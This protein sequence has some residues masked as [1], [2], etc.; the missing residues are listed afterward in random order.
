MSHVGAG[1]PPVADAGA[2]ADAGPPA[3]CLTVDRW[4]SERN[5]LA[6]V[7]M[8]A[9][10]L[11][12]ALAVS[13][14]GIAYAALLGVFFFAAHVG[15]VAH[16]RGSAVRLGPEQMP[17]LH[18]R[19]VALSRRI[20]LEPPAA[21]LMQA[22]GTLNALATRFLRSQ[23]IVLYSELLDACGDNEDARDF[24]IAHEL[25]HLK[26]GHLRGRWF[27][28]PGLLV[29]FLGTAYSRA[30][31]FTSDRYGLAAAG[32]R[33]RALDGLCILAAGGRF[34]P[35]VNRRALAA[36]RPDLDTFW[37]TLGR[38]MSTHPPIAARLAALDP[39][40]APEA[41]TRRRVALA[42]A[43]VAFAGLLVPVA[44]VAGL[45]S[46]VR[47]VEAQA[48]AAIA[49]AGKPAA[50]DASDDDST[51]DVPPEVEEAIMSLV[52][53]AEAHRTA[54]G[55]PPPDVQT[56]YQGWL[57]QHPGEAAPLDPYDGRWYGY[58]IDGDEYEIWSDGPDA[59]DP[60]DDITYS[61][62][63]DAGDGDGAETDPG[64][65]THSSDT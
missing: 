13:I 44:I 63:D 61:S 2:P 58:R 12:V 39:A 4:P 34:G 24:I 5:L 10:A 65:G 55:V 56:L 3:A 48:Q 29:P 8:A 35:R 52:D 30:C 17:E 26:A 20:G 40:L 1:S 62:A 47:R 23:F 14:I 51:A 46:F 60:D 6:L 59:K 32:D 15:F 16:L 42:A 57:E 27:L 43:T 38:W 41:A 54:H 19:V 36:Q 22:G 9:L 21:Y 33:G 64:D 11:W 49:A 45:W 31:E 28:L 25:G 50:D 53:A 18:Q 7:V 37:M